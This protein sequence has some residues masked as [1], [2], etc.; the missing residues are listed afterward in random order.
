MDGQRP[1]RLSDA[2][3]AAAGAR[4][5]AAGLR[6]TRP[7]RAVLALLEAWDGHHAVED[8]TAALDY[9]DH[10]LPRQSVYNVLADLVE[11]DLALTADTGPGRTLYERAS[12]WH[13]HFVCV[14][15]ARIVDV[16]CAQD[17]RP[18]LQ[19][20]LPGVDVHEAQVIYRG[21]CRACRP[22]E[23]AGRTGW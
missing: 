12:S 18:C 2:G 23:P 8:L 5:R 17:T 11:V 3:Q 16:P 9:L 10:G 21:H 13:H 1:T 6:S 4:L 19:P 22:A 14:A 20:D 7:R 15:C